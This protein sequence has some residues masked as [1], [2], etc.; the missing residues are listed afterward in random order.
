MG[1]F[2]IAFLAYVIYNEW[3]KEKTAME[4]AEFFIR[5]DEKIDK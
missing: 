1:L 4:I 5:L 2:F 3:D